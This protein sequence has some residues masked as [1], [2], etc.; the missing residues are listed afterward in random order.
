MS[1]SEFPEFIAKVPELPGCMADGET[2]MEALKNVKR[3]RLE[4]RRIR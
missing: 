2:Y 4:K 1:E 3:G